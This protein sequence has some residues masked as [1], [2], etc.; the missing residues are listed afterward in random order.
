MFNSVCV[1]L[2]CSN[3]ISLRPWLAFE[4][5]V[6]CFLLVVQGTRVLA[7]GGASSNKDILQV[8]SK[9]NNRKYTLISDLSTKCC[10][11]SKTL[12]ASVCIVHSITFCSTLCNYS[13]LSGY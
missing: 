7:T 1:W 8:C 6:M 3:V 5:T 11:K 13:I 12:C 9:T 10:K 2:K 4:I